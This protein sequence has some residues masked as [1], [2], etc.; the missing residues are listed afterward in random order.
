MGAAGDGMMGWDGVKEGWR[1]GRKGPR[2]GG[3]GW[4]WWWGGPMGWDRWD[5]EG[6]ADVDLDV[7]VT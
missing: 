4:Y 1:S 6:R 7:D 2:C 5:A 3:G